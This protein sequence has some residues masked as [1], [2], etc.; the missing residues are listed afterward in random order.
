MEKENAYSRVVFKQ[1]LVHHLFKDLL[2]LELILFGKIEE[3]KIFLEKPR[4]VR[5]EKYQGTGTGIL[6]ESL[7]NAS[8][9]FG[10]L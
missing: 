4:A 9:Q 3:G 1:H 6:F 7:L 10:V 8:D 5:C 2:Y